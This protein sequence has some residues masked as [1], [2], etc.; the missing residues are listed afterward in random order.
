[1]WRE[2]QG[3]IG[4]VEGDSGRHGSYGG[5]SGRQARDGDSGHQARTLVQAWVEGQARRV[6]HWLHS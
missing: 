4:H 6:Q 2:T 5:D 3:D 1:M